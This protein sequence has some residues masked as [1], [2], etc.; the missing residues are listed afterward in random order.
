MKL[1]QRD[2]IVAILAA[3][4]T[5]AAFG[6][7]PGAE[8]AAPAAGN[9]PDPEAVRDER[10]FQCV[11]NA[12]TERVAGIVCPRFWG[13]KPESDRTTGVDILRNLKNAEER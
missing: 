9:P 4:I 2:L 13:P 5:A 7:F 10:L 12:R 1:T 8:V 6:F 11:I 3:A